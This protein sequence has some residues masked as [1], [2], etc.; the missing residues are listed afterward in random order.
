MDMNAET[1]V[2]GRFTDALI[3]VFILKNDPIEC[4]NADYTE[5]RDLWVQFPRTGTEYSS[6]LIDA[7]KVV[8]AFHQKEISLVIKPYPFQPYYRVG[9]EL[10]ASYE[11]EYA[12]AGSPELAICKAGILGVDLLK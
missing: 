7:W 11:Y 3:H 4:F 1:L 8:E 2:E 6:N 9:I 12:V 5:I 10:N